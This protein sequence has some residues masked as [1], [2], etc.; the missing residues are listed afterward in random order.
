[1]AALLAASLPRP[2]WAD[3]QALSANIPVRIKDALVSGD[4]GDI[5]LY[6]TERDTEDKNGKYSLHGGPKV[7]ISLAPGLAVN[8]LPVNEI[9]DT[10]SGHGSLAA[11]A[12]EYQISDQTAR[13]PAIMVEGVYDLPYGPEHGPAEYHLLAVATKF[14]GTSEQ[15]PRLDL[16]VTWGHI[17]S[18]EPQERRDRFSLGLAYSRLLGFTDAIV[19][20]A[21]H[22]Q[23]RTAGKQANF[24]DLGLNH[25]IGAKL[26]VGIGAG[27][28]IAEQSP[29]FR[30]FLGVKWSFR[31][32]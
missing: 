6:A 16:E 32:F 2:A 21:V 17:G 1:M 22:Q 15:A 3:P 14:L 23:Q 20:D 30:V 10:R 18:P 4:L 29:A 12:V 19:V 25:E 27:A 11:G 24:I 7:K 31:A 26:L 9:G 8:L 28:G 13:M 5:G